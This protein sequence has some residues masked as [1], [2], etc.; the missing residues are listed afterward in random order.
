MLFLKNV[1]LDKKK[2]QA[3]VIPWQI[4]VHAFIVFPTENANYYSPILRRLIS[5]VQDTLS[6]TDA[7]G[8]SHWNCLTSSPNVFAKRRSWVGQ[9]CKVTGDNDTGWSV[10]SP[11]WDHLSREKLLWVK[12]KI[13]SCCL[14]CNWAYYPQLPQ[15][16]GLCTV[17]AWQKVQGENA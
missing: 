12:K 13:Q 17:F 1:R 7:W 4:P 16:L 11:K 14:I 8:V 3:I 15:R 5:F 2:R 10:W 9:R 6:F